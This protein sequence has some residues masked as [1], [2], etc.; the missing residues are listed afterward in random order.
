[1]SLLQEFN[2]YNSLGQS[3]FSQYYTL[4]SSYVPAG[5]P[6]SDEHGTGVGV[7]EYSA[8]KS[9]QAASAGLP[10]RGRNP[11]SAHFNV[12][13]AAGCEE[14][15][16]ANLRL[17]TAD[18]S[19]PES[20]PAGAALPASVAPP[21][22]ARDQDEVGRRN[23]VGKAKGKGKKSDSSPPAENDLEVNRAAD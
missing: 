5:L 10:P 18:A 21:T 23:S 17:S 22:G 6:S 15:S 8:E 12:F 16:S 13:H 4:P 9:E 2:S 1:M 7:A 11:P 20:L 3:Q 14:R 19:P